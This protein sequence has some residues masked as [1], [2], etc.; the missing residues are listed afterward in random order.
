MCRRQK[1]AERRQNAFL[2]QAEAC[3]QGR[4]RAVL[5]KGVGQADSFDT[6]TR[7]HVPVRQEFQDGGGKAAGQRVFFSQED[8]L[9]PPRDIKQLFLGQRLEPARVKNGG[10]TSA[11]PGQAIGG[12]Q[13]RPG[14]AP[15]GHQHGVLPVPQ[16]F[17]PADGQGTGRFRQRTPRSRAPRITYGKGRAE[18]RRGQQRRLQLRLVTRRGYGQIGNMPQEGK[19]ERAV[20][21]GAVLPTSPARSRQ[22][23]TGRFWMQ[24][25]WTI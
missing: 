4:L 5:H 24:T 19:I 13:G 22:R 3:A 21:G 14:H 10:L 2:V 9:E 12:D 8:N 20:V 15:D 18:V 23:V 17:A 6:Q 11:F 1:L 25:S 16:P 7:Q